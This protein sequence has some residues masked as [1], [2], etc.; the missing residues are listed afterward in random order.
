MNLIRVIDFETTGLPEAEGSAICEVG[1][2]DVIRD[3]DADDW[4]VAHTWA[5][6]CNPGKPMPPEVRAIHHISDA[7]VADKPPPT[8]FL[9]DLSE[10]GPIAFAAH[11]AKFEQHFFSGAG[12]AAVGWILALVVVAWIIFDLYWLMDAVR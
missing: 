8:Q 6:L 9:A 4:R 12:C 1:R 2:T 3:T 10:G 7:D 5:F 11:N